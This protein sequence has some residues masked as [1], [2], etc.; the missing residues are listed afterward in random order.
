VNIP[1]GPLAGRYPFVATMAILA[2]V[3]YLALSSA[4]SPLIPFIQHDLHMGQQTLAL[5]LGMGNAGYAVGTVLAVM[6][7][8]HFPQR[9]MIVI[10]STAALLGSVLVASA[11]DPGMFIAGHILQGLCTSLLLISAVPPWHWASALR[12]SNTPR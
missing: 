2:L 9:L 8:Q 10:Y 11:Q 12:N 5:G 7:A 4:L 1:S 3:P 6:L